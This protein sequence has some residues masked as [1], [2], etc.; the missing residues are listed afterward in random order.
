MSN[1]QGCFAPFQVSKSGYITFSFINQHIEYS[2]F[3][4]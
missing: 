2:I 3:K 1:I 4:L